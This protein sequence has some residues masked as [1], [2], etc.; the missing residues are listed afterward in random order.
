MCIEIKIFQ[1]SYVT[2]DESFCIESFS[3][4]KTDMGIPV[5]ECDR[6]IIFFLSHGL[7]DEE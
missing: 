4:L 7:I 6:R 1:I 2:Q 3:N 5:F